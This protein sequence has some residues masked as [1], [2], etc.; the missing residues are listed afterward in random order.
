MQLLDILNLKHKQYGEIK[1]N[2]FSVQN[3]RLYELLNIYVF[4]APCNSS[5]V[6]CELHSTLKC[7]LWCRIIDFR[8]KMSLTRRKVS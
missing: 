7:R 3:Y 6:V 1:C 8:L 5:V 4:L 2:Q